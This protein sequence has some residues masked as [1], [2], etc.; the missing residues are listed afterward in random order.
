[1]F[2]YGFG[3]FRRTVEGLPGFIQQREPTSLRSEERGACATIGMT[4][5]SRDLH[6]QEASAG[7]RS[8]IPV[9]QTVERQSSP[10]AQAAR[11]PLTFLTPE[12]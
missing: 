9:R 11:D 8:A 7:V 2:D 12:N 10:P 1:M 3:I 4:V 5:L 6:C